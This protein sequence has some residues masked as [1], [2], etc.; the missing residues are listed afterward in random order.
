MAVFTFLPFLYEALERLHQ[1]A[2]HT[3]GKEHHVETPVQRLTI[4]PVVWYC[5]GT[6]KAIK[7]VLYKTYN[8]TYT[9][10]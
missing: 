8:K 2:T 4:F 9:R 1:F 10:P 5:K 3:E 6:Q 7:K